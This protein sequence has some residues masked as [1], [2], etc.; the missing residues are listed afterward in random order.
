[1]KT[2]QIVGLIS[3]S[4]FSHLHGAVTAIAVESG[5]GVSI[6]ASGSFDI[7][8][9]GMGTPGIGTPFV[10]PSMGGISLSGA[11]TPIDGYL[12]TNFSG[13]SN[14]GNGAQTVATSGSGDIF[15]WSSSG[16]NGS[17]VLPSSY[18]SGSPLFATSEYTGESFASMGLQTGQYTWSW[19]IGGISESFTLSI[20]PE[21]SSMLLV[22][23][24][25]F[26]S[27]VWRRR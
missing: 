8:A 6:T 16:S 7:S 22:M 12:I 24:A 21:P 15:G 23:N 25:A 1:M 14:F 10:N 13:P 18:T 17:L 4:S 11:L 9:L 26:L 3:V 20:V 5:A 27:L 2:Y 19:N